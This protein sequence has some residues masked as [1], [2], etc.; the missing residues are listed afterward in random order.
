MKGDTRSLDYS[1]DIQCLDSH[2]TPFQENTF[3]AVCTTSDQKVLHR[4][5]D[6]EQPNPSNHQDSEP[7]KP[8]TMNLLKYLLLIHRSY[9]LN[10]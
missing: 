3:Q 10:S 7:L 2:D 6:L 5:E 4:H 9:S 1:S 8:K